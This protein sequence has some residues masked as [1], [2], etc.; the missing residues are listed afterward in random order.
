MLSKKEL[1]LIAALDPRAQQEGVEI[2][3]VEVVGAKKAPTIRVLID[4]PDGVSFDEL[5]SS[6]VWINEIMD[7][8]D[9]FPGAYTLEV[10]SPGI[11]RPLC[12]LEHFERHVSQTVLVKAQP[13][14]GRGSWTGIILKVQ[15][16]VVTLDVDGVSV[17]IPFD[18]IKRARL[19]GTIDF[20]S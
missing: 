7:D 12:T 3:T 20:S 9:P 16:G 13:Q 4:T 17:D 10:S 2:Y 19:K 15:G 14:D 6:Q 18:T 8:L 11:D 1:Q 5:T